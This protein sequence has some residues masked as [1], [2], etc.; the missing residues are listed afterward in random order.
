MRHHLDSLLGVCQPQA[1]GEH[2]RLERRAV[3]AQGA[4]EPAQLDFERF[5]RDQSTG[6]GAPN[7]RSNA[8]YAQLAEGLVRLDRT[9]GHRPFVGLGG[10]DHHSALLKEIDPIGSVVRLPPVRSLRETSDAPQ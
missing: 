3:L 5:T 1:E 9:Q 7:T 4:Q 10:H 8:A 2:Q 6:R